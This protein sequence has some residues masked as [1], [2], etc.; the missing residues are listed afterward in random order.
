MRAG[1]S[2]YT[3]HILQLL[4]ND[5]YMEKWTKLLI[6]HTTGCTHQNNLQQIKSEKRSKE[7]ANHKRA[8][9]A[10]TVP[11]L[12]KVCGKRK[13]NKSAC[14]ID[15]LCNTLFIINILECRSSR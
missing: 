6:A 11:H 9:L 8:A 3:F 12:L 4:S 10:I 1:P 14:A 5:N 2:V 7:T 15:K 13:L